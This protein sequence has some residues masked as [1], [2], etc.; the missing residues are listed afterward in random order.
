MISV[1]ITTYGEPHWHELANE[2][3]LPSVQPQLDQKDQV[4]V[5]H[6]PSLQIGPARNAAARKARQPW[7]IFLDADDELE[8][9][10][11]DHMRNAIGSSKELKLF[12]PSVRYTRKGRS[13]EPILIPNTDLRHDNFLVIGT[14]LPRKLFNE[15]GGFN[16]YPHGFEDWSLWAKCWKAGATI[17]HVPEAIYCAHINPHS[18]HK[19]LWRNRREQVALHLRIQAELFPGGV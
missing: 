8:P 12:Q 13:M 6:E 14:M 1:V 9:G 4:V 17:Q 2:R 11:L 18:K 7:L 16:D 3:A 19:T 15:V 5:H 10:Y